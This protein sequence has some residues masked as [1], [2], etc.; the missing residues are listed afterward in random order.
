MSRHHG[1]DQCVEC[2]QPAD[3]TLICDHCATA[4]GYRD[5]LVDDVTPSQRPPLPLRLVQ[6]NRP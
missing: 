1:H 3:H 6:E 2:G 5:R 4:H